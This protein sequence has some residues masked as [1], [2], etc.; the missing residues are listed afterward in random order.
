MKSVVTTLTLAMLTGAAAAGDIV[1]PPDLGPFW[2]PLDSDTGTYIYADSFVADENGT[3]DE[4]GMWLHLSNGGAGTGSQIAFEVYASIG[5]NAANG[6]DSTNVLASTGLIDIGGGTPDLTLYTAAPAF[7]NALTAGET[8]WFGA[9]VIDGGANVD[10]Y[11]VG[12]HTQNSVY[13]DNGTFWYSND[14]TG[15]NFDGRGL[16]P[17]MAFSVSIGSG[18]PADLDGDGDTDAD[19]FFAYLDGFAAGNLDVC[20]IDGDED[21]DADDFFGY[22]DLFAQGC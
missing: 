9:N 15:V 18:C 5:G 16:T 22:L 4:L 6:P 7:S 20:D 8:Y 19:D 1:K 14:P 17:E 21:C 10:P 12:G 13:N 11:R 2:N 3:V